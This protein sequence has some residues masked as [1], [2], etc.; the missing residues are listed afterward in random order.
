MTDFFANLPRCIIGIESTGGAHFWA[1]MLSSFGH[2][3]R[4]MAPQ[5]VKPYL[6]HGA[7]NDANDASAIC[8]AVS[9]PTM[10]FVA[11]KSVG[12]QDLQCIHRVRSRLIGCRTQLTNQIR[13]LLMEYGI[14]IPEHLSQVRKALPQLTEE[15]DP[16]LSA[17][18]K[19]LF[20]GLYEELCAIE[21][22]IED[23][24]VRV[25]QAFREDALCTRIGEVEG[26]G[27]ITATAVVAAISN[28]STF[29][30]GRQFAAW[31]GLVP[32]QHSS[33]EKQRLLGITKRGDP[34][35]RTLLIH[36]ARSVVFRCTGK[37]DQR[38]QWI[39]DKAKK[40]GVTK[41]CV[42]VANKNARI[43]WALLAKGEPYR[44]A[45]A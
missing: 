44:R 45:A 16:R 17:V 8:E 20:R 28:G 4:L 1:R 33:G 6:K 26:I 43:V 42:A 31:L 35:L 38:S 41:A 18:A 27:P 40:L 2:T 12:Q 30:N 3:V 25:N 11:Q 32:R 21:E 34:Y 15:E 37:T 19:G 23:M 24:E 29:V 36:G 13:G 9:R 14:T 7:K 39:S 5:L 22:R 10:R